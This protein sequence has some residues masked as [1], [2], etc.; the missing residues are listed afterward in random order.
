M[1]GQGAMYPSEK[2]DRESLPD[3]RSDAGEIM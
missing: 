2:Y 1:D 3:Y